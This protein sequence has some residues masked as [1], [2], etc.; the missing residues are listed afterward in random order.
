MLDIYA[1]TADLVGIRA[2]RANPSI[3]GF[4]TNPT[5]MRA[6]GVTDY[7]WFAK[8]AQKLSDGQP[9]SF[10]V[11]SDDFKEMERQARK[12]AAL[13]KNVYVKIPITDTK[14][15]STAPVIEALSNDLIPLNV[16]AVFTPHQVTAAARAMHQNCPAII[17]IFAGRIADSGVD[18]VPIMKQAVNSCRWKSNIKVL[19]ASAREVLNI[20]QADSSGCHIITLTPE[21][22]K[23]SASLGKPLDKFSLET[24]QMFYNDAKASGFHL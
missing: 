17:S 22:I 18:P 24:V 11:F 4:T 15:E 10:E 2:A 16:T 8:E 7:E 9:I 3:K 1:D 6:A 12:L 21:L 13:G 19:W 5:L 20:K 14:G 23:K